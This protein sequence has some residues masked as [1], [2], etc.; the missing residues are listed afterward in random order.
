MKTSIVLAS[1]L[2]A[3]AA[4]THA[5]IRIAGFSGAEVP[6][7]PGWQVVGSLPIAPVNE[8][9]GLALEFRDESETDAVALVYRLTE[10]Q[11]IEVVS[12]GCTL[13]AGVQHVFNG[14]N[15][16]NFRLLL[17][18]P[19][20]SSMQL[21]TYGDSN[22]DA[23]SL[24]GYDSVTGK[25]VATPLPGAGH[26]RVPIKAVFRPGATSEEPGSLEV[27]VAGKPVFTLGISRAT[28]TNAAVEIGG[29]GGA[30]AARIGH[31]FVS[32]FSLTTP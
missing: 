10:E 20:Y 32:D 1:L 8:G 16:A 23:V 2:L 25:S 13:V 4:V 14:E 19:G 31:N 12:R 22:F 30:A 11:A 27:T 26:V 15:G 6:R 3:S 18:V 17:R 28:S 24:S 29:S 5:E 9:S 7:T 21:A